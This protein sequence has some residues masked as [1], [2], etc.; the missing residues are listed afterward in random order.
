MDE[1]AAASATQVRVVVGGEEVEV[2]EALTEDVRES[3][4]VLLVL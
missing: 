3:D 2:P 1:S 4:T